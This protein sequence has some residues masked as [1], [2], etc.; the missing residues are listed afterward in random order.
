MFHISV[1]FLTIIFFFFRIIWKLYF[2]YYSIKGLPPL[3]QLTVFEVVK[4]FLDGSFIH[5]FRQQT[6][7]LGPIFSIIFPFERS[8]III[9]ADINLAKMILTGDKSQ[10]FFEA[11]KDMDLY[12][13][14]NK[15]TNNRPSLLTK[16]TYHSD[17]QNVRKGLTIYLYIPRHLIY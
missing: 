14:M 2:K 15:L 10:N 5:N 16:S 1:V 6:K 4:N 11:E 8:P 13:F 17:W 7:I 3:A 9:I 12:S